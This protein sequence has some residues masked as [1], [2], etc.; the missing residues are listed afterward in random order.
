LVERIPG[1]ARAG[2]EDATRNITGASRLVD[3]SDGILGVVVFFNV[4]ADT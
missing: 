1:N 2:F 4:F 3:T